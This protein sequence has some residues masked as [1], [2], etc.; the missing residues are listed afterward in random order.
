MASRAIPYILLLYMYSLYVLSVLCFPH[1]CS[2]C[3]LTGQRRHST[4]LSTYLQHL[5]AL[6]LSL[7]ETCTYHMHV[8]RGDVIQLG[9]WLQEFRGVS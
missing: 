3:L 2:C 6:P 9:C 1:C 5:H 4:T 7:G 8:A